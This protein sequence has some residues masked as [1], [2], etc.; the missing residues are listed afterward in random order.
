M[1][2]GLSLGASLI[3]ARLLGVREFGAYSLLLAWAT[4]LGVLAVDGLDALLT[5]ELAT[6][7]PSS[8]RAARRWASRRAVLPTGLAV[9]GG[10]AGTAVQFDPVV[11]VSLPLI[12]AL[13]GAVR[14]QQAVL[15]VS[16]R[17][18]GQA[19][20]SSC[21]RSPTG[22]RWWWFRS[23]VPQ[24]PP[25]AI[26]WRVL[27]SPPLS[28][29]LEVQHDVL[30]NDSHAEDSRVSTRKRPSRVQGGRVRSTDL[31]SELPEVFDHLPLKANELVPKV[32]QP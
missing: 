6:S 21:S 30:G 8:H 9:L 17:T 5:R 29:R 23:S 13:L 2:L 7:E 22:W 27:W 11:S 19:G 24:P 25:G 31:R 12:V 20:S 28:G 32:L 15:L 4:V 16:H 14:L 10:L 18:L 3:A 1:G 26:S